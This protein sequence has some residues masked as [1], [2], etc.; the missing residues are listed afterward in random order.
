VWWARQKDNA[1]ERKKQSLSEL[2]G[3]ALKAKE[4]EIQGLKSE[5]HNL[6]EFT[7]LVPTWVIFTA[8]TGILL[9]ILARVYALVC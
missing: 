1:A 9:N 7:T 6:L 3:R 5:A 8:L 4:L 2:A